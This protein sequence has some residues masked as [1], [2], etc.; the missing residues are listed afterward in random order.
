MDLI[1][2]KYAA[3]SP[4]EHDGFEDSRFKQGEEV[5]VSFRAPN[6][7]GEITRLT[8]FCIARHTAVDASRDEQEEFEKDLIHL[9]GLTGPGGTPY[10]GAASHT[11]EGEAF[12]AEEA[13]RKMD[14]D[15]L[16]D[17]SFN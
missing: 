11:D 10:V 5:E 3:P 1:D 16:D 6:G 8:G 12:F 17:V 13:V 2:G 4:A 15:P 14:G 7:A 9:K